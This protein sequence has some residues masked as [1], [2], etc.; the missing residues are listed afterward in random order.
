MLAHVSSPEPSTGRR[1]KAGQ[2]FHDLAINF[3]PQ[4]FSTHC[5]GSPPGGELKVAAA[6]VLDAERSH[7]VVVERRLFDVN[8]FLRSPSQGWTFGVSPPGKRSSV[9]PVYIEYRHCLVA[10]NRLVGSMVI[11]RQQRVVA[12]KGTPPPRVLSSRVG[13]LTS[14]SAP[15]V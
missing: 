4:D 7:V 6:I 5:A 13:H 15:C 2:R 8:T 10:L 11:P 12:T 1:G 3:A 9:A 14:F